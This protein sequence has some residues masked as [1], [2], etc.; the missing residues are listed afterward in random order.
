MGDKTQVNIRI[1]ETKKEDWCEYAEESAEYTSLSHL[2]RLA[3][4]REMAGTHSPESAQDAEVDLAP[5]LSRIEE[6]D[7]TVSTMAAQMDA[8][9]TGQFADSEEIDEMADRLYDIIPRRKL[10]ERETVVSAARDFIE[11]ADYWLEQ[12]DGSLADL[13]EEEPELGYAI[14]E[15][16]RRMLGADEYEMRQAIERLDDYSSR[17]EHVTATKYDVLFEVA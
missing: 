3:V 1:D 16:Y 13:A 9:E 12:K 10:D 11:D 7:D 8:L 14:V 4:E 2:M 6:L 5:L 15:A 17:V